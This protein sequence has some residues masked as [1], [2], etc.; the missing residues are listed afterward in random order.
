MDKPKL[1]AVDD[2]V[3]NRQVLA[4]LF[5]GDF[6][7]LQAQDGVEALDILAKYGTAISVVLLDIVMP[8]KDGLD[9]LREMQKIELYSAIPVIVTSAAGDDV[10]RVKALELG[11][12]DYISSPFNPILAKLRVKS[13]LAVRAYDKLRLQNEMLRVQR[14]ETQEYRALL[15][16]SQTA[17]LEFDARGKVLRYDAIIKRELAGTYDGRQLTDIFAQDGVAEPEGVRALSALFEKVARD[18]GAVSE[19]LDLRLLRVDGAHAW[20]RLRLI[21]KYDE[22]RGENVLVMALNNIDMEKRED[23]ATRAQLIHALNTMETA[24][25][26]KSDFVAR[27]SHEIRTPLNAIIGYLVASR[28]HMQEPERL[29]EYLGKAEIASQH[30]LSVV[31]DVLDLSAVESGQIEVNYEGFN[32]RDMIRTVTAIIYP[33]VHQ[34]NLQFQ[35]ML[36]GIKYERLMGDKGRVSQILLNLLGNAVRYTP[37]NADISLTIR[38][39]TTNLRRVLMEF[40]VKDDG[41]G[42]TRAYVERLRAPTDTREASASQRMGGVGLGMSI[43][44]GLVSLMN[45][46]MT[47]ES[48]EGR[49]STFTVSIPMDIEHEMTAHKPFSFASARVLVIDRDR[50]SA[51]HIRACF[52]NLGCRCDCAASGKEALALCVGSAYTLVLM[53]WRLPDLDGESIIAAVRQAMDKDPVI[54]VMAYDRAQI[55]G[56]VPEGTIFVDKPVFPSAVLEL[57]LKIYGKYDAGKAETDDREFAGKRLLLAEDNAVNSEIAVR[58]LDDMGFDVTAVPDG[59]AAYITF[60]AS[61][62]GTFDIIL[63]DVQMPV[64][65]GYEATERIRASSHPDAKTI[66]ILA[67][68]ANTFMHDIEEALARGMTG[69]VAK[70][71]EYEQMRAA[72]RSALA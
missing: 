63:M 56:K 12:V 13:A 10:F 25:A 40:I 9:V 68:T 47:V 61:A 26:A 43:T 11:A 62:P 1:L 5:D 55:V 14:A 66:P 72:I 44:K 35:V 32:L 53:D 46:A 24:S 29:D 58:L 20:Y 31:N 60:C 8:K 23:E 15:D 30:L 57:M 52:Q 33:A 45:G 18:P 50:A 27:M 42:M 37:Q 49:G 22:A 4:E 19:S 7:V 48:A 2:S 38:Q 69:H 41:I 64:M 3:F 17:V 34:K 21:K 28:K 39:R 36:D 59:E 67:V 71:I 6:D 51:E 65:D 54:V 16:D 70:P